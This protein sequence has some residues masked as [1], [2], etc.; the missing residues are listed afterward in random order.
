MVIEI[1]SKYE[2][3]K[4]ELAKKIKRG[5]INPE[6]YA[7]SG[8]CYFCKKLRKEEIIFELAEGDSKA[9]KTAFIDIDCLNRILK[10]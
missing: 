10:S 3:R 2:E 5:E 8:Y 1:G 4:N 6:L 9:R 7:F